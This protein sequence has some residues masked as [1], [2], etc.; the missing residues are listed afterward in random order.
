MAVAMGTAELCPDALLVLL[1]TLLV[2]PDQ[3][4]TSNCHFKDD[5]IQ[6]EEVI[7]NSKLLTTQALALYGISCVYFY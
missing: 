6:G 3:T 7:M 4:V 5:T 2:P 1:A